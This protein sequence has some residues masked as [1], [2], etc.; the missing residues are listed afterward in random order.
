MSRIRRRNMVPDSGD[1][2]EEERPKFE[3]N[4]GSDTEEEGPSSSRSYNDQDDFDSH[5]ENVYQRVVEWNR[6]PNEVKR[7]ILDIAFVVISQDGRVDEFEIIDSL[8][9]SYHTFR[10]EKGNKFGYKIDDPHKPCCDE[11]GK[12]LCDKI[13]C[14]KNNYCKLCKRTLSVYPGD[15]HFEKSNEVSVCRPP[16]NGGYVSMRKRK[17]RKR[18]KK[19]ARRKRRRRSS[20][21]RKRR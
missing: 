15:F 8:I 16:V 2:T 21:M 17:G 4:S 13:A 18:T 19:K 6:I 11:C 3:Y 5:M 12:S 9:E 7:Q 10:T 20:K 1:E 14:R